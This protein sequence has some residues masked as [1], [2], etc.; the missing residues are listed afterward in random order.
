MSERGR[1]QVSV[2][3]N[4]ELLAE[5]ERAAQADHRTVSGQIRHLVAKAFEPRCEGAGIGERT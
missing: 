4:R 1:R 3:L 5:V 2:A